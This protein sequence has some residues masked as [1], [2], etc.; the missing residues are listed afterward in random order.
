MLHNAGGG[1]GSVSLSVADVRVLNKERFHGERLQEPDGFVPVQRFGRRARG[2]ARRR[3]RTPRAP[4]ALEEACVRADDPYAVGERGEDRGGRSPNV[5]NGSS[6]A[7]AQVFPGNAYVDWAALD[8]N[9]WGTIQSWARWTSFA[10]VFGPSY[11]PL[12]RMTNKPIIIAELGCAEA[13]GDKAAWI[14]QGFLQE[15]PSKLPRVRAIVCS[16]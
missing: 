5:S 10:D 14:R 2:G 3:T 4:E 16:K 12:A 11:D 8:G 6:T 7:F 1:R 15:V 13:G 9:N